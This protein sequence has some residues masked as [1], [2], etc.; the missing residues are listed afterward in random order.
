MERIPDVPIRTFN[1]VKDASDT[2]I[3]MRL[4]L[5]LRRQRIDSVGATGNSDRYRLGECADLKIALDAGA[6]AVIID[7]WNKIRLI[8]GNTV[9]KKDEAY[10]KYFSVFPLGQ[11]VVDF[12]IKRAKYPLNHHTLTPWGQ[13]LRQQ[14]ICGG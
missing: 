5:G 3:A 2:E 13:P 9:L 4:C 8:N 10:G 7:P 6:E 12:S 1:P 11:T 14:S